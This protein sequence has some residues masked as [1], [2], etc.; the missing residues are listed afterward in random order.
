MGAYTPAPCLTPDLEAQVRHD[1]IEPTLAAMIDA[2]TPFQGILFAGIMLTSA[3]PQLLE[4]NVRFGDPEAQVIL[5][6]LGRA[7]FGF[8]PRSGERNAGADR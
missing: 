7:R 5:P 8:V 6:R 1:I 2:G 4:Y 3:G